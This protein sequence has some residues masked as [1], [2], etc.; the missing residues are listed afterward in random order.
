LTVFQLDFVK[1]QYREESKEA[2]K[3]FELAKPE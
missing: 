3:R 1:S 2:E